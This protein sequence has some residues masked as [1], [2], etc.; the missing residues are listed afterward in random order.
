[1]ENRIDATLSDTDKQAV[2]DA[3]QT[4]RTKL[5]FLI[6]LSAEERQSLPKAGDKSRAFI[7]QSLALAEQDDSFLPRSFDVA[8]MRQ[9]VTLAEQL[10]P[11]LVAG[12]Q[13]M[14]L[15]EDTYRL[16][17]V[18]AYSAGLIVY[19]AAKD[20]GKDSALD[21]LL[22]TLGQRFARKSKTTTP[23]NNDNEKPTS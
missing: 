4:I 19:R 9:D 13:F 16:A 2:L 7:Q 10:Y 22:D 15:L 3:F 6:G 17:V 18:D 8:E 23:G 14:E 11:I 1:M 21:A 5:P 20:N 12:T